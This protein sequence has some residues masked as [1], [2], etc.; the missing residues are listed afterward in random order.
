MATRKSHLPKDPEVRSYS[1]DRPGG[2][3]APGSSQPLDAVTPPGDE[4][5]DEELREEAMEAGEIPL[6][7]PPGLPGDRRASAKGGAVGT[8]DTTDDRLNHA[9]FDEEDSDIEKR[10]GRS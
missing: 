10:H 3:D 5:R 7:Q 9:G 6:T 1:S 8:P 4:Q 2:H